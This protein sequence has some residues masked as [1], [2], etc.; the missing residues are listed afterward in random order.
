MQKYKILWVI[1]IFF[2]LVVSACYKSVPVQKP[3]L[4]EEK[5]KAVLKDVHI[6]EALLTETSDRRKKDSLAR[7]YYT[8]IL[9]I[10]NVSPED[11]DQSMNAYF[12]S[13][14]VLDSLYQ[15]IILD[16]SKEKKSFKK[17]N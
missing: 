11:F 15:K 1:T 5:I 6:A 16:L 14:G 9:R 7:L 2:V 4:S 13:P 10:H 3:I 12:T 8:Q 17:N